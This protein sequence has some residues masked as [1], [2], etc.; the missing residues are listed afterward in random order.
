ML[1][2]CDMNDNC[3]TCASKD[4]CAWCA[5]ESKCMLIADALSYDCKGLVFEPP[6]PSN[7]IPDNEVV[8][9][10]IVQPDPVFGGGDVSIS[11]IFGN[12]LP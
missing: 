5:S 8:G 4:Y 6:C 2:D 7:F 3:A 11:G 12:I 1:P 10:L 9:N